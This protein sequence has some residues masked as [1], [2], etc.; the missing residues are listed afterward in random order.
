M[1]MSMSIVVSVSK[2]FAIDG[3][4]DVDVEDSHAMEAPY[5]PVHAM[6]TDDR[7]L[8]TAEMSIVAG[9]VADGVEGDDVAAVAVAGAVIFVAVG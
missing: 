3:V 9:V 1:T 6:P 4:V 2:M 5:D 7:D 8:R